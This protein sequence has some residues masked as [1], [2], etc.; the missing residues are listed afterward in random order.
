[1]MMVAFIAAVDTKIVMACL[2][3]MYHMLL[4]IMEL[5]LKHGITKMWICDT[6]THTACWLQ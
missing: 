1:M 2:I 3:G 6:T 5:I 4:A